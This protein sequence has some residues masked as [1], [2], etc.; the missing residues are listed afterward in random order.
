MIADLGG[1]IAIPVRE[2]ANGWEYKV[3]RDLHHFPAQLLD[4]DISQFKSLRWEEVGVRDVPE[5]LRAL[6]VQVT[7]LPPTYLIFFPQKLE[8][9]LAEI[10]KDHAEGHGEDDIEETHFEPILR[11]GHYRPVFKSIR[12]K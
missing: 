4:E 11:G 5:M 3:V 1:I 9:E 10:E 8:D 7:P 12:F 2:T 6:G